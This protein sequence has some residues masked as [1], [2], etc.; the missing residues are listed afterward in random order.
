MR[1]PLVAS[2]VAAA[3]MLAACASVDTRPASSDPA[4]PGAWKV[5]PV[6]TVT[7]SGNASKS[8]YTLGRYYDGMR[9]WDRSIDAY[10]KAIAADATNVEAHNAL[11]AALSQRNRQSEAADSFRKALALDAKLAH[12]QSNL[13][14]V[15]LL[16]G[17]HQAAVAALKVAVKL[18][19]ANTT[20]RA[21]LREALMQW[22]VA[23][24]LE[25]AAPSFAST[26]SPEPVAAPDAND[27]VT[28]Q[29]PLTDIQ[30]PGGLP[31]S[32]EV[33]APITSASVAMPMTSMG[34]VAGQVAPTDATQVAMAP[35]AASRSAI[36]RVDLPAPSPQA[37]IVSIAPARMMSVNSAPTVP[38][39]AQR[40]MTRWPTQT[41]AVAAPPMAP[42]SKPAVDATPALLPP[43]ALPVDG[44]RTHLEVS[45]AQGLEGSAKQVNRWLASRGIKADRQSTHA[46][47]KL[48][49]S[50]IY[51]QVGHS[52]DANRLA[53]ALPFKPQVRW[54]GGQKL[55]HELLLV[56]G[57]DGRAAAAK[58]QQA[59]SQAKPLFA[60]ASNLPAMR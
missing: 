21:N 27:V 22:D 10:Q 35:A 9:A 43:K 6:Q 57:Q 20:A 29:A 7:H 4:R 12:V 47:P 45:N 54:A 16:S 17:Q 25:P 39:M 51:Y 13:G 15:L 34:L 41:A 42:P 49:R 26:T 46:Q 53:K 3:A 44:A 19:P 2:V 31:T 36:V 60:A 55:T 18:E 37:P 8:Y 1:F 40:S 14:Y 48:Q 56:L 58:A 28:A 23:R 30:T 50:I 59:K 33:M 52:A 32:V 11:G 38:A 24:G 5:E